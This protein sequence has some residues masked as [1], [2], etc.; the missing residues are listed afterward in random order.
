MFKNSKHQIS[1]YLRKKGRRYASW[2]TLNIFL[3]GDVPAGILS[4]NYANSRTS[5][6]QALSIPTPTPAHWLQTSVI[7]LPAVSAWT[8]RSTFA[9]GME[10][11]CWWRKWQQTV[12]RPEQWQWPRRT[13]NSAGN[14][15]RPTAIAGDRLVRRTRHMSR[16]KRRLFC[17][18]YSCYC[19]F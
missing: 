11:T 7:I 12:A 19:L 6:V 13:W 8:R 16:C 1:N 17:A 15:T 4:F 14:K 18:K 2:I 9:D 3:I 5:P 10:P